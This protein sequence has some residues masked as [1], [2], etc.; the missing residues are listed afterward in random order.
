MGQGQALSALREPIGR[1]HGKAILFGDHFAVHGAPAL[2]VPIRGR[3][4]EVTLDRARTGYDGPPEAAAWV[5]AAL[6]QLGREGDGA[7]AYALDPARPPHVAITTTLPV[8]AGLGS[9][10][11]LAV[12]LLRALGERDVLALRARA[13]ALE[14]IAHGTPSGIDD[15][16]VAFERPVWLEAG[17][18]PIALDAT[19]PPLWVG[20]VP[21]TQSTKASVAAVAAWRQVHPEFEA[22]LARAHAAAVEGRE[23][24]ARRAWEMVG[25]QMNE[26]GALLEAV[27]AVLP[28]QVAMIDVARALGAWGAKVAG[29]GFGGAVIALAPADAQLDRVWRAL[30]AT[31]AFYAGASEHG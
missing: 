26:M 7:D 1:A 10:A 24:L 30:G 27:G 22:L 20:V 4:V 9:S 25:V 28:V 11:A 14:R 31:D 2:A 13:H 15:A 6:A 21:R 18:A 19:V 12:A 16:T 5:V 29:A 8:A 23:A 17:R 3:G